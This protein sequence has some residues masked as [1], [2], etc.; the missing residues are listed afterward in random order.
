MFFFFQAEDGIRDKL[1]TG[2]QTC[3]L[4]ISF[5]D[6]R[7][8]LP[9]HAP[10]DPAAEPRREPARP[11]RRYRKASAK[12]RAEPTGP[13]GR[14]SRGLGDP[15]RPRPAHRGSRG[16]TPPRTS[17]PRPWLLPSPLLG[18]WTPGAGGVFTRVPEAGRAR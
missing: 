10:R 12:A 14:P 2:V 8:R 15:R 6:R 16:R 7:P 11:R 17:R 13:E 5:Q 4:P 9:Q 3:A 18:G 1:V